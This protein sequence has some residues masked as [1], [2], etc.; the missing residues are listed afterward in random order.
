MHEATDF[1]C[2]QAMDRVSS[3]T[4]MWPHGGKHVQVA[5]ELVGGWDQRATLQQA[6]AHFSPCFNLPKAAHYLRVRDLAPGTY[7]YKFIVD[8]RWLMDR[9][10]PTDVDLSGNWNNVLTVK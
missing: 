3:V 6:P 7:H 10:A 1:L 4:V 9:R 2:N 8:N 5:G